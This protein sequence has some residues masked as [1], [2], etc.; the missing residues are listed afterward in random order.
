MSVPQETRF[1]LCDIVG[2]SAEADGAGTESPSVCRGG[3][4]LVT[5]AR[6]TG[7]A[8]LVSFGGTG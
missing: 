7:A 2:V 1:A 6:D 3:E 5:G 8:Y 4:V